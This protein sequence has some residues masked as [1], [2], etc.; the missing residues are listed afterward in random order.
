MPQ[1]FVL[2]TGHWNPGALP[3]EL[4]MFEFEQ[5]GSKGCASR[6]GATA[7][8]IG[9]SSA[10]DA[11]AGV[12]VAPG[13][14]WIAWAGGAVPSYSIK[15]VRCTSGGGCAVRTLDRLWGEGQVFGMFQGPDGDVWWA[16]DLGCLVR[17]HP[18][19]ATIAW[20]LCRTVNTANFGSLDGPI[21]ASDP[22]ELFGAADV[23][24]HYQAGAVEE[25]RLPHKS[26]HSI[27]LG[28][29]EAL[30]ASSSTLASNTVWH[31]SADGSV[32]P[33]TVLSDSPIHSFTG[34]GLLPLGPVLAADLVAGSSAIFQRT[35][36]GWKLYTNVGLVGQ[37]VLSLL[38]FRDG[39]VFSAQGGWFGQV[40][41]GGSCATTSV[42][43][44]VTLHLLV[45]L[46][47]PDHSFLTSGSFH[48]SGMPRAVWRL[49]PE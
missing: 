12:R 31:R 36:M 4:E 15:E 29:G 49:T 18:A 25:V 39:L 43:P 8:P 34:Q 3:V 19:T 33:E 38:P 10:V 28:R 7:V 5:R 21:S 22:F 35:P 45:D 14:A 6:W 46:G 40:S 20:Q 27:W 13:V 30:F 9:T 23:A 37:N 16:S 26:E 2:D 32:V 17:S 48:N 41:A 24:F 42:E 11:R 47:L 44:S 1:I